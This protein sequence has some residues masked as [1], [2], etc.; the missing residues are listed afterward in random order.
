MT[1]G[2][3]AMCN[4]TKPFPASNFLSLLEK[5]LLVRKVL[6]RKYMCLFSILGRGQRGEF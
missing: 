3:G 6:V 1:L 4:K 5:K 2:R